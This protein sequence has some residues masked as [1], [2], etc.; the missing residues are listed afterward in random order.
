MNQGTK[1]M[2]LGIKSGNKK[3]GSENKKNVSGNKKNGL[4]DEKQ[5]IGKENE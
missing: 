3:N 4:V 2:D 1:Q 5:F